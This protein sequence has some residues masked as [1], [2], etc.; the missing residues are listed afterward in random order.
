VINW[1][2][3]LRVRV[4]LRVS[5][6][7]YIPDPYYSEVMSVRCERIVVLLLGALLHQTAAKPG[8][9]GFFQMPM[10]YCSEGAKEYADYKTVE[11]C[12]ELCASIE[13]CVAFDIKDKC[14]IHTDPANLME[15]FR[16]AQPLCMQFRITRDCCNNPVG[17]ISLP[18]G[19]CTKGGKWERSK[20]GAEICRN[21]CMEEPSCAAVDVAG[22]GGCFVHD[23]TM[24]MKPFLSK[25]H[26]CVQTRITRYCSAEQY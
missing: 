11:S 16:Q 26:A 24:L 3:I 13:S 2:L 10:G 4:Y 12:K 18:T 20:S 9:V 6:E 8:C 22:N 5:I 15:P 19:F 23:K 21:F 17:Y 25:D 7:T 1:L 14:F